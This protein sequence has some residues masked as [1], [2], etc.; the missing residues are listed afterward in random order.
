MDPLDELLYAVRAKD[1]R[2]RYAGPAGRLPRCVSPTPPHSPLRT[3][4]RRR[5]AACRRSDRPSEARR[6]RRGPGPRAFRLHTAAPTDA[7]STRPS[8]RSTSPAT[9]RSVRSPRPSAGRHGPAGRRLSRPPGDAPTPIQR[10]PAVWSSAD[11]YDCTPLL[12][13]IENALA[14]GKLGRQVSLD[15]L[16]DWLM[17]C[18]LRDWFDL[19]SPR[20]YPALGDEVVGPVLQAMHRSPAEPWTLASLAEVARSPGQPWPGVSP[21]S[22]ARA[23]SAYLTDLR[24]TLAADLLAEP[25]SSVGAVARRIG[26]ADAFS[27]SSAFKRERG[28]SPSSS[29]SRPASSESGPGNRRPVLTRV[30]EGPGLQQ[31][32]APLAGRGQ[33]DRG[34][35]FGKLLPESDR[36]V[37]RPASV[38]RPAV[39]PRSA[40]R[41]SPT[42]PFGACRRR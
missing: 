5:V 12:D 6:D 9:A 16:V 13:Y 30:G 14:I 22:P 29:A 11:E 8:S 21:T 35:Q 32:R 38:R 34:D 41:P 25:G 28:I 1:R 15:R 3:P 7:A 19:N 26:Y 4:A 18:T 42:T 33:L 10:L 40:H 2:S 24:M 36:P 37:R 39:P 27:F 31:R 17:V 20:W 23:R